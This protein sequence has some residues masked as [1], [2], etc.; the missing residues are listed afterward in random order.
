[1][2]VPAHATRGTGGTR[3]RADAVRNR[4]RI[5]DAAREAFVHYGPEAPL[6]EIARDAGVGNATLYRHFPDRGT[7]IHHVVRTVT[8]RIADRAA[9]LAA[10]PDT[11]EAL[12]RFVF[13]AAEERIGALC[14][15]LTDHLDPDDPALRAARDRLETAASHLLERAQRA[16]TLRPDVG[17]GDL[18][19]ALSQLARPLPGTNCPEIRGFVHRHLQIFLDGLRAPAGSRLT[20]APATFDDLRSAACGR[21]T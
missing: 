13:D 9:A 16:G 2:T 8:E 3:L 18:M 6:D 15:L 7:L 19:L 17:L 11:F 4:E 21:A 12:R 5:V 1:M 14:P 10:E 20:G